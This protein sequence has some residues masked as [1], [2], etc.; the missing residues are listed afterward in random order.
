M[1]NVS[2]KE[3]IQ[4]VGIL[5][6]S[7]GIMVVLGWIF[8]IGIFKSVLPNYNT[9][10]FNA[11]L[12]FIIAG[13]AV[14]NLARGKQKHFTLLLSSLLILI[15]F[16]TVMQDIIH[17]NLGID[18]LFVSDKDLILKHRMNP[19]RMAI[20]T[21]LCF[22]SLGISIILIQGGTFKKTGQFLLHLVSLIS[23]IAVM[24]YFYYVPKFYT[25]SFLS[26]MALHTAFMLFILS[27]GISLYNPG[28]G[29]TGL[30][31]GAKIG[32]QMARRLFPTIVFVVLILGYLR[33]ESHL[34]NLVNVEFGIVLFGTSCILVSLFL[35]WDT[36]NLLNKIDK[37]RTIAEKKIRETNQN[38]EKIVKERTAELLKTEQLLKGIIN[39]T[40]AAIYV[41]NRS[42]QFILAN[43]SFGKQINV[44]VDDLLDK[45]IVNFIAEKAL[46]KQK[47]IDE[48]IFSTGKA[49]TFEAV[50]EAENEQLIIVVNKF[51][52]FDDQNQIYAIGGVLT[53]ITEGRKNEASLNAIF[54][55]AFVSII[56]T[57]INGTITHFN[58]GAET[59]LGYTAEEVI[60]NT[61]AIIHLADEINSRG[62]ELTQ[63][64]NREIRGFDV[65]VEYARQGMPETR[66]WTYVR[67]DGTKFPVQ[68]VVT[69]IKTSNGNISGFLGVATD[70]S[71]LKEQSA[72]IQAQKE[73]L[74][75]LNAT[76]DK[77]FSIV[78]H[79]LRSPLSSLMFFSTMLIDYFDKL[80]KE[81][82]ITMSKELRNSVGNTI[83]MAD[84][85]ITWAR[86]QM[87]DLEYISEKI[88]VEEVFKNIYEV[89]KN[90]AIDK[91]I[92]LN[93]T[94][95]NSVAIIGDK[96]Q[97]EFI[98]RNLINNAIKFTN[99]GGFVTLAAKSL[100]DGIVE[101]S[102]S[103]N[104]VGISEE[105]QTKLFSIEKKKSK[106]GTAGEK[107]T[108]LG[109]ILSYEFA[110]ANGGQLEVESSVGKGTIFYV[111]F[112]S[113]I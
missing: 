30:F 19:G 34:L 70:I 35:V 41:K 68:L 16:I 49:I 13:L 53:D 57:D 4:T 102:V 14:Y 101:I 90:V 84:N 99:K 109:L 98:V 15:G 95:D 55:A 83:K 107:G 50:Y 24:G 40:S 43:E 59:L 36:A 112:K 74:E 91:N 47:A 44:S 104:G 18:E 23:F 60:G 54:N 96:N 58:K 65:F 61:P 79:D 85:L 37:R 76:K 82:I 48:I 78:A 87:N 10:K 67:K 100:P 110:K 7:L 52:L 108:G 62:G 26:S 72:I 88:H 28:L 94:I 111:R 89:Y 32:N 38:L 56:R 33:T 9:M 73:T 97:I 103:D 1:D 77:F 39:N 27:L 75:M 11:A 31:T 105:T 93:Y 51:P 12:S 64:Y 80:S 46:Q 21:A 5:S 25:L 66:E 8:N 3:K 2:Y 113:K 6:V 22:I 42:N 45:P 106:K 92:T 71:Q 63:Q 81:E 86:K 20:S 29:L 17:I 69:A